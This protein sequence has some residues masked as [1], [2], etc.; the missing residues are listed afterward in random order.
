MTPEKW[1]KA[2]AAILKRA[3]A[4]DVRAF[5][6][7]AHYILPA[8]DQ[9]YHV[10]QQR[11]FRVAGRPREE[12]RQEMLQQIAAAVQRRRQSQAEGRIP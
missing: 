1:Q 11:D 3:M 7:L 4:G 8:P 10:F 9:T 6:S 2:V 12:I 5:E